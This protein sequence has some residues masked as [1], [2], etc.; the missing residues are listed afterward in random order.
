MTLTNALG[1]EPVSMY[2]SCKQFIY[3]FIV[4]RRVIS[5]R[6]RHC[7]PPR[8]TSRLLSYH[9]R[10]AATI[11]DT[12][13]AS[14]AELTR[15]A[16]NSSKLQPSPLSC[17][18]YKSTLYLECFPHSRRHDLHRHSHLTY[19]NFLPIRQPATSAFELTGTNMKL[20]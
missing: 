15:K 18:C 11:S 12:E 10:S 9:I 8:V 3:T 7:P 19:S 5:G 6:A 14:K 17:F 2:Y 13:T 16:I 4:K 1:Y 20:E